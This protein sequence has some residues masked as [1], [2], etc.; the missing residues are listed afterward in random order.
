[1]PLYRADI[2]R[3]ELYLLD[4]SGANGSGET[5]RYLVLVVSVDAGNRND[6]YPLTI[7]IPVGPLQREILTHVVLE[8]DLENGLPERLS[9]RCEQV[10]TVRKDQLLERLGRVSPGDMM[11]IDGALARALALV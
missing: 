1:M 10:I 8:P 5:S 2:R 11:R 4:E 9:A 3:G 6:R 7:V